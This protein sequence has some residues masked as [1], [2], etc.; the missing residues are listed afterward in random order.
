MATGTY[1]EKQYLDYAGL[2]EYDRLLK[3]Y[4]DSVKTK[5][6]KTVLWDE[7]AEVIK[8]YK[9]PNA[10]VAD[11]AD[12]EVSVSS[13]DV[14]TLQTRVG[15]TKT[16]NAYQTKDNLT[17]IVNVLT[18]DDTTAGSVLKIV[19]D[20]IEGLKTLADVSIAAV[21]ADGVVTISSLKE[22]DGVIQ[23]GDSTDVTLAKVATTA[24]A[25]DI[26]VAAASGTDTETSV[27]WSVSAG[28]AQSAI[29]QLAKE[30]AIEDAAI[31][32]NKAN[33]D[34]L[35]GEVT[36]DG[37]VLKMI[38]DNAKD[39]TYDSSYTLAEKIAAVSSAAEITVEKLE[40]ATAG[41]IASYVVK[42]NNT[43][44]GAT[45]DIPKDYL[46]KDA[47]IKVA[48]EGGIKDKEG[49]VIIPE[50]HKY[51]DF[52]INTVEGSGNESHIYLDILELVE[53]FTVADTDE[54]HLA[55]SATRELTAEIKVGS[56]ARTKIDADFEADITALEGTH[57]TTEAGAFKSVAQEIT[58]AID[59]LGG[60]ATQEAGA[61]GLA[62]TVTS[63]NGEVKS[64]SGS[65]AANTYDAYGDAVIEAEAS[66]NAISAI[67]IAD[68]NKIFNPVTTPTTP[69]VTE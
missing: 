56:I 29:E 11:K 66:H 21:D 46:V 39:A 48:P 42:Q 22:V 55:L 65:I 34:K 10:V 7:D 16:L 41:Y 51:I 59:A 62:L 23:K 53:D 67:S 30:N 25:E 37:S 33:I 24:K 38:K 18:A 64:I 43:Q 8:F 49:Q 4:V 17:E 5:G 47:Q 36:A 13:A 61:D 6:I 60:T 31:A 2:Q 57:A 28:T 15:I 1:V 63:E 14:Q 58:E 44:V 19:T 26:T 50:G 45:I 52:T 20:A 54:I 35:N 9:D 12:F 40:V 32:T 27:A 3:I 69:E 68:I